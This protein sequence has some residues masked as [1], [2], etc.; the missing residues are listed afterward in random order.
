MRKLKL[1]WQILIAIALAVILG[2]ITGTE[3][4]FLGI[5]FYGIYDFLGTLFLNGLLMIVVPLIMSSIIVSIAKLGSGTDLGR[6]GG[7]T[8]LYYA[9]T[10]TLSILVG[11]FFVNLMA[12]GIINGQPAG[13]ALNL[14]VDGGELASTMAAVEGRGG[15]DIVNIFLRMVPTNIVNAAAQG[16]MLGLIFFSLVFGFFMSRIPEGPRE[17]MLSFWTGVYETM[18]KITMWIMSFA[19]I[20]VFGLVAE[21]VA[22]TGFGAFE[23]LLRFFIT[24]VLAL[25]FHVFVTLPLMLK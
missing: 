3:T 13:D 11:L 24:V 8:F 25:S 5:T 6:L 1:H 22:S 10:S 19:P 16:E 18:M 2:S 9:T 21:T 12:P 20:G 14:T 17:T 15:G 7:K 4:G 23:P